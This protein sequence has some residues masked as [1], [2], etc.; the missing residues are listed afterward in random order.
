MQSAL[1]EQNLRV[2]YLAGKI[3]TKAVKVTRHLTG[4]IVEGRLG[5]G[6]QGDIRV[7]ALC[8]Y[9]YQVLVG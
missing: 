6:N 7:Y 9:S 1:E 8:R 3:E 4:F 2:S 5:A